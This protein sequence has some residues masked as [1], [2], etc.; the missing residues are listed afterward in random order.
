MHRLR[1]VLVFAVLLTLASRAAC[2]AEPALV[3]HLE[4]LRPLLGKTW[5]GT[6]TGSKP[7]KPVTDIMQWERALNGRA[8]RSLHSINDGDYGGETIFM[9]DE[10]EQKLAYHYFTT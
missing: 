2:A 10:K 5:K 9:W 6:F 4:P 7:E 8:V 1:S 3:S